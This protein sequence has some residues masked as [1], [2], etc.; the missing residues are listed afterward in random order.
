MNGHLPETGRPIDGFFARFPRFSEEER[1]KI[2]AAWDELCTK[3]NGAVR[4][5]GEDASL[6]PLRAAEIRQREVAR[7]TLRQHIGRG[8]RKLGTVLRRGPGQ[9]AHQVIE[10][11]LKLLGEKILGKRERLGIKKPLGFRALFAEGKLSHL[12]V[13]DLRQ[14]HR[15]RLTAYLALFHGPYLTLRRARWLAPSLPFCVISRGEA[16]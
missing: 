6:H 8:R 4:E 11:L 7:R 14:E 2:R 13:D 15:S 1:R 3:T 16:A 10:F 9:L 12:S 5:N